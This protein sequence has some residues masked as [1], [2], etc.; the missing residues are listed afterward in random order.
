MCSPFSQCFLKYTYVRIL[1]LKVKFIVKDVLFAEAD[2]F[3][4]IIK[5]KDA[6]IILDHLGAQ[7]TYRDGA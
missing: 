4:I 6:V 2:L 5:K 3:I 7:A 1:N